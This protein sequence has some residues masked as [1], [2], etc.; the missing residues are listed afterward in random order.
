MPSRHIGSRHGSP[1]VSNHCSS[2]SIQMP[3]S[4]TA[5]DMAFTALQYLPMPLLVLSSNKTI[6][7]AN[8]ALGRLLGIDLTLTMGPEDA[9]D[10]HELARVSSGPR[11]TT[12]V[13][14]GL[15]V[16]SLGIDLLQNGSPVWV[17]W[18]DFL[19]S[20]L[21]DAV[22]QPTKSDVAS[23]DGDITPKLSDADPPRTQSS[24]RSSIAGDFNRTTIHEV[25]VDVAFSPKRDPRTGLPQAPVDHKRRSTPNTNANHIEATLIISV[26]FLDGQQH[27]T[28]TFTAA[29]NVRSA[30][31]KS[32]SRS[33][34]KM[35]RNYMS[36]MGSGSSSSSGGRRTQYSSHSGSPGSG[37]IP[38]LPNGPATQLPSG[39]NSTL[40]SK[41]SKM[42]DAMINALPMPVYAMWK[43]ESFGIPNK[44]CLRLLGNAADEDADAPGEREF[45]GQYKIYS[46][47]FSKEFAVDD[48]PIFHLMRTKKQ[49]TNMRVGMLNNATRERL[50]FDVDGEEIRDEKTGE[51]LGGLVIFRDVTSYANTINAQKVQNERQFEDITNTIPVM[52]WTATPDGN[53]DYWSK[54]WY[55]Y[56]GLTPEECLGANW[57]LPFVTEDAVIAA[58]R[59]SNSMVTGNEYLTEYRCKSRTGEYRWML[60]RALPMRDEDGKIVKWFGTCTDI[61]ELVKT[62]EAA[63]QTREQLLKVIDHANITL[64]AT[65]KDKRLI[66]HEGRRFVSTDSEQSIKSYLG[67]N[68]FDVLGQIV[69][70]TDSSFRSEFERP[71]ND[72]LAGRNLDEL[73][74]TAVPSAGRWYR[75][76]FVPLQ[77]QQRDGGIEGE[78][79]IDGVVGLSMD[80]TE[81]RRREEDLRERDRENGRLLAQSEAAKEAS[82]MKSQFLANMSH[83]I[84]TPIAGVIGMAELLLDDT[85]APL[86]SDQ[87]ECA[88]NLQRSA[89]GLLTVINDILDFSKVESGRLDIEEVQ[90][91]LNV[92][93]RDVNKMLSFAAE[94][95]GLTFIDETQELQRLKVIGD[96]G[97]LRQILTNLLTNSIKF[98]SEGHVRMAIQIMKENTEKVVVKFLVEDTGIGIEEEVRKRL[99]QP[100][101][102]ADSSTARRFGGTGLGLTISKNLVELMHGDI[103][104][105]SVLGQGTRAT[106]WIPFAKA[107]FYSEDSPALDMGPLP[108]RLQSE[109]SVSDYAPN[110]MPASPGTSIRRQSSN[111]RAVAGEKS[112]DLSEEERQ[113]IHVLVVEDNP[114]N[115]QIALKTIKK[116][117]FS[118]N[119]VWNGQEALDYLLKTP[120]AEHPKPDIILM[121]VQMPVMDGY[122]ATYTIRHAEPFI[123]DARI[124]ST[125]IVAMTASAIQGDREKCESA[126][127]NDYLSKPVKGNVLEKMLVKWALEVKKKRKRSNSS[128]DRL[129]TA[130][131][132]QPSRFGP[133]IS[134]PTLES[135]DSSRQS[136]SDSVQRALPTRPAAV[137]RH[138]S[139]RANPEILASRLDSISNLTASAVR[140]ASDTPAVRVQNH[141]DNEEK[142]MLLRDEQLI[143]SAEDPKTV[144]SRGVSDDSMHSDVVEGKEREKLTAEN[145]GR[146][147][148]AARVG[149]KL[150]KEEEEEDGSSMK[151]TAGVD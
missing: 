19:E 48:Y 132:R 44:A 52:I 15:S 58:E 114:I 135:E 2:M 4:Q 128:S 39:T 133:G 60:G 146:L 72:V 62:R 124:Q 27:Y 75:T 74:E 143:A 138:S 10:A 136:S 131:K 14:Y 95:K 137:K 29:H 91:D 121:D 148:L 78:N 99:F 61:H 55:D 22:K 3:P 127:M 46:E 35:H 73:V 25:V 130:V 120:T 141:F 110:S 65:D 57:G 98:T 16:R 147:A 113:R 56:T 84:R 13:L 150:L 126:G 53:V 86:S 18:E 42:K 107:P 20:I 93:V 1:D 151:A 140:R 117:K 26:W 17:T 24:R 105:E 106:F 63:K 112:A 108:D 41:S 100:F 76:R 96:P 104:L 49:F 50:I 118:V 144:L 37:S 21:D 6:V 89:N 85:E 59:W 43:D 82:K 101:S 23:E 115:Q 51:F 30:Q 66:L 36:G 125:P 5:M 103:S 119:A 111:S 40:L 38:W 129:P 11:S 69:P 116:L 9:L 109:L 45:V 102:Q 77:R 90:F 149:R 97:R 32:S 142:A 79:V 12:D 31:Q 67:Q 64:W 81:L 47:D 33:V 80:V 139:S 134:R 83:E 28:L 92:V 123:A 122:K 88:E 71:M 70:H 94:R 68:V 8:E 54:R 7:L 145:V 87:R 34:T